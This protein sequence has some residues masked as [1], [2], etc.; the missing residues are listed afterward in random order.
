MQQ[1]DH[2]KNQHDAQIE[3]R[4]TRPR[5]IPIDN[6]CSFYNPQRQ[7][8]QFSCD[9]ED[10]VAFYTSDLQEVIYLLEE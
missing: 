2:N 10:M 1:L 5:I 3:P 9:P 7:T 8:I 4:K 6:V